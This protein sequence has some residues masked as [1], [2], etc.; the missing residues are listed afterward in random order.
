MK[1]KEFLKNISHSTWNTTTRA[2]YFL[3][4]LS[5]LRKS[6]NIELQEDTIQLKR[7]NNPFAHLSL[8]KPLS[9]ALSSTLQRER[10][11]NFPT[12]S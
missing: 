6:N 9:H 11:L 7:V 3:V 1:H 8:T 5:K 10:H 12:N 4:T 2:C